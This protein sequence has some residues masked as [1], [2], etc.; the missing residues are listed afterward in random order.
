MKVCGYTYSREGHRIIV[1]CLGC[2]YGASIEDFEECMAR[3]IDKIIEVK[4]VES[5]GLSQTRDFEYDY[6]QTQLL[7]E[8]AQLVVQLLRN[9]KIL[10]P[11][12]MALPDNKNA[13]A[14]RF[15][16]VQDLMIN[17]IRRDPIG[18]Y[19]E[20]QR[21]IRRLTSLIKTVN[22]VRARDFEH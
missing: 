17:K 11:S 10:T 15:G 6:E 5:I 3:T 7:V 12:R 21:E 22:A 9:D 13:I 8:I 14:Q 1:N 4:E 2:I 20:I 19:V 16:F 18:T